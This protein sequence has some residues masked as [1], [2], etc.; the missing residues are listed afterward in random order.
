MDTTDQEYE[1]SP[2]Q[3]LNAP[4][5]FSIPAMYEDSC[6]FRDKG[7]YLKLQ[8]IEKEYHALQ[9]KIQQMVCEHQVRYERTVQAISQST[10]TL[11]RYLNKKNRDLL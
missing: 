11:N 5:V 10:N 3:S 7:K 1:L 4:N 9:L 2:K 8:A 6:V